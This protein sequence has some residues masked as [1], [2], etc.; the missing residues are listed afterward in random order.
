MSVEVGS[1]VPG[2]VT[3][4]SEVPDPVFAESMVGPGVAVT[5]DLGRQDA[6]APVSGTVVTLH[7]HAF[8]VA[9]ESGAGVLVHLGIDTVKLQGEGFSLHVAKGDQVEQGQPLITWDPEEVQGHGYSAVC[10]VVALDTDATSL[11]DVLDDGTVR[12]TDVLFRVV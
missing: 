9:T 3:P 4:M 6:V 7:P 2:M 1:P 10:P 8:V 12:V 5:P 11:D